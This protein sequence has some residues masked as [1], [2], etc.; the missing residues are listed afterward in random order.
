MAFRAQWATSDRQA[1]G[2][3]GARS[4]SQRREMETKYVSFGP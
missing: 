4:A 2:A 1:Y 3:E